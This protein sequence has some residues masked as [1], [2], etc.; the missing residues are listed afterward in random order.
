[1]RTPG[2]TGCSDGASFFGFEGSGSKGLDFGAWNGREPVLLVESAPRES[3]KQGGLEHLE[4]AGVD[5]M[6]M[7]CHMMP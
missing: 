6:L 7:E 3:I 2:L 5:G 1:M 4:E